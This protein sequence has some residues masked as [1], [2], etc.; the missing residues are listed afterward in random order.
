MATIEKRLVELE[1]RAK[2]GDCRCHKGVIVLMPEDPA[3]D[4]RPANCPL[5]GEVE[6]MV[7]R[8]NFVDPGGST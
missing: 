3:P 4:V 7:I 6:P 8:I 2:G 1:R 5:H